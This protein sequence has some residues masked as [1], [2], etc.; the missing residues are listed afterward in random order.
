MALNLFLDRLSQGTGVDS[1]LSQWASLYGLTD[2]W[3]WK[4]PVDR[5]Y[6]CHSTSYHAMSRID[7]IYVS[8][9]LLSLVHEVNVLPRGISDHAPVLRSFQTKTPPSVRLWR[10]SRYW[11]SDPTIELEIPKYTAEF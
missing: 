11:I 5:V 7:L 6:T 8:G 10:L 2:V 3:W 4:Y 9:G 1:P